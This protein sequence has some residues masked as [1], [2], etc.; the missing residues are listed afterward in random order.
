MAGGG[1]PKS[2]SL[3]KPWGAGM[4]QSV[5]WERSAYMA[6]WKPGKRIAHRAKTAAAVTP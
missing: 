3:V 2:E 5:R 1:R 6:I 4:G